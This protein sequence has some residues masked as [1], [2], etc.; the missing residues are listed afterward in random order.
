MVHKKT[1][2]RLQ[3]HLLPN[4]LRKQIWQDNIQFR[5]SHRSLNQAHHY[6][7]YQ[8]TG[9][10]CECDGKDEEDEDEAAL[11]P[12]KLKHKILLAQYGSAKSNSGM[13][14]VPKP[15]VLPSPSQVQ[16]DIRQVQL[17]S[18][19]NNAVPGTDM[20][21]QIP[22]QESTEQRLKNES[23]HAIQ[24]L[25]QSL[26][27]VSKPAEEHTIKEQQKYFVPSQRSITIEDLHSQHRVSNNAERGT[28]TSLRHSETS[29]QP[30]LSRTT[31]LT[32]TT[33]KAY[34]G[35]K[36][37]PFASFGWNDSNRNIGQ[38]KTYNVYAPESEVY[39]PAFLALKRRR[40]E[41]ERYLAEEAQKR[42]Q[43]LTPA[44]E[45]PVNHSSIWMT[46]Y[47]EK[48]THGNKY[49]TERLPRRPASVP[50]CRKQWR[51]S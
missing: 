43:E 36:K 41:I 3:F 17:T 22:G 18:A 45:S 27:M 1:E 35:Q 49:K 48:F 6:W 5:D 4:D 47:Q 29:I 24:S 44:P 39:S 46:E 13:Q 37:T 34:F 2:Y 19:Q 16:N 20:A 50:C 30:K 23:S 42:R 7:S 9:E 40:T 21:L 25:N 28:S 26:G 32:R 51:Y 15:H 12:H 33:R 11:P 31:G 14:D 8:L 10:K 38:K